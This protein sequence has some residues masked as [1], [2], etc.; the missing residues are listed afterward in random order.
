MSEVAAGSPR[1]AANSGKDLENGDDRLPFGMF[2]T[3]NRL[4]YADVVEKRK[5]SYLLSDVLAIVAA[6]VVDAFWCDGYARG[7]ESGA[8]LR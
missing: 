4:G 3:T 1:S 5:P 6:R 7:V 2:E 8:Y